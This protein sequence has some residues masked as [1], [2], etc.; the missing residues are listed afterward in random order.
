MWKDVIISKTYRTGHTF[1]ETLENNFKNCE[2]M[3]ND[4]YVWILVKNEDETDSVGTTKIK[5]IN[6]YEDLK[7]KI[8][9]KVLR[10]SSFEE[11]L[12]KMDHEL[13]KIENGNLDAY[14]TLIHV[15]NHAIR[16]AEGMNRNIIA[17]EE[18][19]EMLLKQLDEHLF[20]RKQN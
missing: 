20:R 15:L 3:Y 18:E 5:L 16:Y 14:K 8:E 17:N 13:E 2:I 19:K 1:K 6:I 10:E 9:E 11:L 12:D 4:D 7:A